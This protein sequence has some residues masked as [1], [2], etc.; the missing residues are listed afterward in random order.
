MNAGFPLSDF[1]A[2]A[3]LSPASR[4]GSSSGVKNDH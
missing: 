1:D 2:V 3:G 4:P